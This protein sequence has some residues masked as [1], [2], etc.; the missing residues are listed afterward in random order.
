MAPVEKRKTETEEDDAKRQKVE[1]QEEEQEV[2]Q[3]D[4]E[5]AEQE[6][7]SDED[8]DFDDDSEEDDDDEEDPPTF[9]KDDFEGVE[10]TDEML[11]KFCEAYNEFITALHDKGDLE[12]VEPMLLTKPQAIRPVPQ[13]KDDFSS[14]MIVAYLAQSTQEE[15]LRIATALQ[16]SNDVQTGDCDED[17]DDAKITEMLKQAAGLA[18]GVLNSEMDK[19]DKVVEE[20]KMKEAFEHGLILTD[21]IFDCELHHVFSEATDEAAA[22]KM[23]ERLGA[24]WKMILKESDEVLGCKNTRSGVVDFINSCVDELKKGE[25]VDDPEQNPFKAVEFNIEA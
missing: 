14:N 8:E 15:K 10:M 6:D 25:F 5:N 12:K 7:E 23:L 17:L 1:E 22:M 19:L 24:F 13:T 21:M 3:E 9:R 11:D 18:I 2:E 20:K 4:E 16:D